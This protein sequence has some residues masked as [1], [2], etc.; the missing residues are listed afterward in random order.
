MYSGEEKPSCLNCRRQKEKCDYSLKLN[1]DGR[2]KR[3]SSIESTSPMSSTGSTHVFSFALSPF[4]VQQTTSC[5][6]ESSSSET[7]GNDH[8][9]DTGVPKTVSPSPAHDKELLDR[10]PSLDVQSFN[11]SAWTPGEL[12]ME[13]DNL[14]QIHNPTLPWPEQSLHLGTAM[15]DVFPPLPSTQDKSYPSPAETASEMSHGNGA[16]SLDDHIFSKPAQDMPLASEVQNNHVSNALASSSYNVP[17]S[18]VPID[19][20]LDKPEDHRSSDGLVNLSTSEGRWHMYLNSATDNYGLDCGRK[21]LDLN[22]ND[23]HAAIDVRHALGLIG[24]QCKP[25]GSFRSSKKN[26]AVQE[27]SPGATRYTYYSSPVPVDI[28]RYLSPLPSTLLKNP[29]N[30]MYF[31]HFINHTARMLVPHDC[32]NNPFVSVLPSS[33]LR[34]RMR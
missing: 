32:E 22:K 28:P 31:H 19:F 11:Q 2:S 9:R 1:W 6:P 24:L 33:K 8:F 34:N 14:L 25:Q 17:T 3:R 16:F 30:L 13:I 7:T 27:G 12:P 18:S 26:D 23:D 20:L 15:Q 10:Q 4:P 29:I 21:D 5:G